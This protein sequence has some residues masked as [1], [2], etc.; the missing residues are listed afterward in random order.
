MS[1]ESFSLQVWDPGV[2]NTS[3]V[4][5]DIVP[6]PVAVSCS[7]ACVLYSQ[8]YR[9]E[10]QCCQN[11]EPRSQTTVPEYPLCKVDVSCS[12]HSPTGRRA[13]KK[14]ALRHH[15]DKAVPSC[16]FRVAL[17]PAG[18]AVAAAAAIETRLREQANSL[19]NFISTAHEEL[20]DKLK[21]RKVDQLLEVEA[22]PDDL[23]S[24][25]Y[26]SS[27]GSYGRSAGTGYGATANGTRKA[28]TGAA[29]YGGY[30]SARPDPFFWTGA[31]GAGK[32]GASSRGG[33]AGHGGT[34]G[35]AS[36]RGSGRARQGSGGAHTSY[37]WWGD[38]GSNRE[39]AGSDDSDTDDFA[40]PRV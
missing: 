3:V 33:A 29:G 6:G 38:A 22:D 28:G 27:T 23:L 7:Q 14:L 15:P 26:K 19:F 32:A 39:D 25:Y 10:T 40:G 8:H 13:F 20:S 2:K 36:G 18:A 30:G 31:G 37:A 5:V 16:R 34:N 21:R 12:Y 9:M 17:G 24:S 35:R 4:L 1:D 11:T